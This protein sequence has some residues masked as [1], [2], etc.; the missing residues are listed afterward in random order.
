MEA[1]AIPGS[2]RQSVQLLVPS[3]AGEMAKYFTKDASGNISI[4]NDQLKQ[5][6]EH[7]ALTPKAGGA[8]DAAAI[9]ISIGVDF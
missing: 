1:K 3:K 6:L 9:K 2:Q 5:L 8:G 4:K 7:N